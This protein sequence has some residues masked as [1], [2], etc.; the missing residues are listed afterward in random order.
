MPGF[1]SMDDLIAE[2]T[3]N[4]K[5]RSAEFS[6]ISSNGATSAAGRWHEFFTATG[7]PAA[8]SFSGSAG[9]ATQLN[10]S[11]AGS[12]DIGAN[13]STDIRSLLSGNIC[14]PSSVITPAVAVLVDMLLYYPSV[15]VTGGPT[16]LN[17]SVTLPRYTDGQG[18]MAFC[19]VQTALGAASPSL[20][21]TYTDQDGNSA[22]S[23]IALVS[24]VNS[25]PVSTLFTASGGPW[26]PLNTSDTGVKKIDSYTIA[27]GTTGTVAFV[28]C[29]PLTRIPLL[30]QYVA[31]E[32]DFLYQIPSM[33]RVYDDACL[34]WLILIGGA[35]TTSQVIMGSVAV[36]WG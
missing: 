8:G 6:K 1:A 24:P 25:A 20:T 28:L 23:P 35:M 7:I 16:S 29:K 12:M 3:V 36:G 5:F 27:S 10:R 21:L 22:A 33:P 34:A 15:V 19:A 26:L 32:R 13:V 17:N 31:S 14:T 9:V 4:G 30:A 2:I 11:S 18:V